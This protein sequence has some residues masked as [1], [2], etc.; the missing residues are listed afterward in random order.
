[1]TD[2][3]VNVVM[4]PGAVYQAA[5][6]IRNFEEVGDAHLVTGDYDL[7]VQLELADPDDLPRVVAERIHGVPGVVDTVTHVAYEP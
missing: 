4:D 1:M 2:A 5:E 6:T 7:V 3:F